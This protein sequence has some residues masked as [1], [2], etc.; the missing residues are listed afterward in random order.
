MLLFIVSHSL[1]VHVNLTFQYISCYCLSCEHLWKKFLFF[2]ISIHLML[3]FIKNIYN[4]CNQC[5]CISIHLML[6]FISNVLLY[7]TKYTDFNTSH[8]TV[9]RAI[10]VLLYFTTLFQYISCYCLSLWTSI[11]QR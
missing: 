11:C 9:Y 1:Q 8:V 2:L 7:Q 4:S 5:S 3:L 6:L 10:N